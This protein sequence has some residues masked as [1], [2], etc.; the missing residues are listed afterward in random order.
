MT[1]LSNATKQE[2][3]KAQDFVFFAPVLVSFLKGL[4]SRLRPE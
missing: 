2:P 1:R 3:Q 4:G